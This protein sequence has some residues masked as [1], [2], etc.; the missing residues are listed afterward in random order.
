MNVSTAMSHV[1]QMST[2][3]TTQPT[4]VNEQKHDRPVSDGR[5]P[6]DHID[7]PGDRPEVR[8]KK[9]RTTNVS[10][11]TNDPKGRPEKTA[12]T[13]SNQAPSS[14]HLLKRL[15]AMA[16]SGRTMPN[17]APN[18]DSTTP[19]AGSHPAIQQSGQPLAQQWVS[20]KPPGYRA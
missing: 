11:H 18:T 19:A 12:P 3:G 6:G 13:T 1:P 10:P 4:N 9:A 15:A 16:T 7:R 8:V 20:E 5:R 17:A 14:E 2:R